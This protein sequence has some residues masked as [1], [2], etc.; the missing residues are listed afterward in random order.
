M[1]GVK[2]GGEMLF[3][4]SE[5]LRFVLFVGGFFFSFSRGRMFL[6][7][8]ES[9][10]FETSTVRSTQETW[11]KCTVKRFDSSRNE[12]SMWDFV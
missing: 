7:A 11:I 5:S 2:R 8:K 1:I 12:R 10:Y 9:D 6:D 4:R 3:L